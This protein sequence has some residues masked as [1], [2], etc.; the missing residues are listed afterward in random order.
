MRS[1]NKHIIVFHQPTST[2]NKI[3]YIMLRS[4]FSKIHFNIILHLRLGILIQTPHV[5]STETR[6]PFHRLDCSEGS[7][8]FRGWTLKYYLIHFTSKFNFMKDT[9]F[10]LHRP[11]LKAGFCKSHPLTQPA[12]QVGCEY[13]AWK[14]RDKP[15]IC[16]RYPPGV[17][18]LVALMARHEF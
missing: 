6:I 1:K 3:K 17:E 4:H 5:S 11:V 14:C 18:A 8:W 2:Q 16:V 15:G 12:L 7:V 9:A 13:R 10:Y